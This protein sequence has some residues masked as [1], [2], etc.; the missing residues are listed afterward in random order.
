MG[1][2]VDR[3]RR[4]GKKLRIG[5]EFSADFRSGDETSP[6]ISRFGWE[7]RTWSTVY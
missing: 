7:Q 6:E 2:K 4:K 5:E 1:K 3:T